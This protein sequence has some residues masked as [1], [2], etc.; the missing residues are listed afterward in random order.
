VH[1][2]GFTMEIYYDVRSRNVKS[3]YICQFIFPFSFILTSLNDFPY[4]KKRVLLG[5]YNVCNSLEL[6]THYNI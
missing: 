1:L 3:I 4:S 6:L 5:A 2:V